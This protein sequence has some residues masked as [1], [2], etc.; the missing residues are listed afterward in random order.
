MFIVLEGLDATGKSEI[1]R[2]LSQKLGA[3][4]Y[5]TP[6]AEYRGIRSDVDSSSRQAQFYYYLSGV[7]YASKQIGELVAQGNSVVC[8]RYYYS[9]LA[10]FSDLSEAA[11]VDLSGLL[12]PDHGFMLVC[13]ESVRQ[14]RA[15]QRGEL[16]WA[17]LLCAQDEQR[18]R[19]LKAYQQF[20]LRLVDTS[21]SAVEQ[22]VEHILS[23]MI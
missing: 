20:D 1:G 15:V 4:F 5:I 7:H 2:L 14:G 19:I 17:E 16:N 18:A 22:V 3:T 9:T 13:E 8:D 23:L 10:Y 21:S 11:S 12:K 6:P